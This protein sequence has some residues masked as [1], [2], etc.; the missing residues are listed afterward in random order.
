MCPHGIAQLAEFDLCSSDTK[1]WLTK[2]YMS[3]L[4]GKHWSI[5][6]RIK[7]QGSNPFQDIIRDYE[8]RPFL[9]LTLLK[10]K[11]TD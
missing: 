11:K 3:I 7:D 5:G 10:V 4:E 8:N 9:L 2:K 6:H 1:S